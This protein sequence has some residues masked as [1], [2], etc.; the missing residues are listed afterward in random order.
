MTAI[1]DFRW[2]ANTFDAV[3]QC[4]CK[5]IVHAHVLISGHIFV[6]VP[7]PYTHPVVNVTWNT[8]TTCKVQIVCGCGL[9]AKF[10]IV[11]NDG[12]VTF[13]PVQVNQ[14]SLI[15]RA[16]IPRRQN[17]RAIVALL[18]CNWG[19]TGVISGRVIE[20][21]RFQFV[22]PSEHLMQSVLNRGPWAYGER[23]LVLQRWK[24]DLDDS[25]LN[26][27]LFWVQIR[28]IPIQFL[29]R[30]V[31]YHIG[32]FLGYVDTINIIPE[33]SAAVQFV[34]AKILWKVTNPLRLQKNY[35]FT[36]GVNTVLKFKY[37]Q[38]R[39]FCEGCGMLT[40]DTGECIPN[41]DAH[42]PGNNDNDD[43]DDDDGNQMEEEHVH[44]PDPM[45]QQPNQPNP[46]GAG[47]ING[48]ILEDY[49]GVGEFSSADDS[50]PIP[51]T[52]EMARPI[53]EK[54]EDQVQRKRC[55]VDALVEDMFRESQSL[56]ILYGSF[57]GYNVLAEINSEPEPTMKKARLSG[58]ASESAEIGQEQD[59][60]GKLQ[61]DYMGSGTPFPSLNSIDRGAVG[62]VTPLVP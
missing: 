60:L 37:E 39:G 43:A 27:I 24:P 44:I 40:H 22:F 29:T 49:N 28:G 34:R 11:D 56:Q 48:D 55:F 42:S 8:Q 4:T 30:N 13:F 16:L 47:V 6:H 61:A 36:H 9:V 41:D 2:N 26:I 50:S 25:D 19:L 59:S 58:E 35:Q 32:D 46:A 18:P 3:Y 10:E 1:M 53:P 38:L 20:Q 62:P 7:L 5:C 17:L 31:I 54:I 12:S 57:M 15:G 45:I 52:E 51:F 33:A 14:F 23:M 21:W